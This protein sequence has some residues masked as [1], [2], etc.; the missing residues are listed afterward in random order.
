MY[1]TVGFI[2]GAGAGGDGDVLRSFDPKGWKMG[3]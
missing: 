2:G 1:I 3:K